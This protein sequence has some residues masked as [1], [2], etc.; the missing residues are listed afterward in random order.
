[1]KIFKLENRI[2]LA[3]VFACWRIL[4]LCILTCKR[5]VEKMSVVV[6][7]VCVTC[8]PKQPRNRHD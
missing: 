5:M 7:S 3:S 6:F 4:S 1:M 8:E 2:L